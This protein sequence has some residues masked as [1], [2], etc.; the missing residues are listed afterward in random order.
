[1]HKQASVGLTRGEHLDFCPSSTTA[2]IQ[3]DAVTIVD[4][5]GQDV[6]T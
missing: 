4:A 2:E 6:T 1:M 5:G 3:F